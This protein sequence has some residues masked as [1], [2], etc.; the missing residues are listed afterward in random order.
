MSVDLVLIPGIDGF[1]LVDVPVI[2]LH[3]TSMRALLP[4]GPSE[5]FGKE[6]NF[7]RSLV[8]R[9]SSSAS[10]YI[11][12]YIY[13]CIYGIYIYILYIYIYKYMQVLFDSYSSHYVIKS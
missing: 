12:I 8:E 7:F 3:A 13:T 1:V 10:I 4:E 9:G 6:A 2:C 11:Y 5:T